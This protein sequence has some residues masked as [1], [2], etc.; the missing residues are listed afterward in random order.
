MK[1]N[2]MVELLRIFDWWVVGQ[3]CVSQRVCHTYGSSLPWG[4]GT[5][6]TYIFTYNTPVLCT[7]RLEKHKLRH[8]NE[9]HLPLIFSLICYRITNFCF[10]ITVYHKYI[11]PDIPYD[12]FTTSVLQYTGSKSPLSRL[13]EPVVHSWCGTLYTVHCTLYCCVMYWGFKMTNAYSL[14]CLLTSKP[15]SAWNFVIIKPLCWS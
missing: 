6:R 13:P 5:R 9:G 1:S 7:I 11:G 4:R 8:H 3:C 14:N 2:W 15:W 12:V 10:T